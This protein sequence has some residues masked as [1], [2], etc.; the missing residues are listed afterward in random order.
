MHGSD[1]RLFQHLSQLA[2]EVQT[3]RRKTSIFSPL[4]ELVDRRY[5]V[6]RIGNSYVSIPDGYANYGRNWSSNPLERVLNRKYVSV[7]LGE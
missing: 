7:P 5:P 3:E 2:E 6:Y 4:N 1:Q